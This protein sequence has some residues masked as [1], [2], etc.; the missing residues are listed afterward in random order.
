M[1]KK[2][3]KKRHLAQRLCEMGNMI[4]SIVEKS[5]KEVVIGLQEEFNDLKED[6]CDEVN[7]NRTDILKI[8]NQLDEMRNEKLEREKIKQSKLLGKYDN[9][10]KDAGDDMIKQSA[11]IH[12]AIL[13][14]V[15][16]ERFSAILDHVK[17]RVWF[18][19]VN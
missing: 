8:Q 15:E 19:Q 3:N 17:M 1:E 13:D 7:Q 12:E 4:A 5:D 2:E 9:Q 18:A 16:K 14:R 6:L 11:I 10:L